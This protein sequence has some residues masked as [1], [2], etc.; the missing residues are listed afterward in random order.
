MK[1][2]E[3]TIDRIINQFGCPYPI[4]WTSIASIFTLI[5][6]I[7]LCHAVV[8]LYQYIQNKSNESVSKC[9]IRSGMIIIIASIILFSSWVL[10]TLEIT[11]CHDI[12]NYINFLMIVTVIYVLS[13][14]VQSYTLLILFYERL[15]FIFIGTSYQLSTCTA[16]FYKM[17]FI[18]TPIS[19]IMVGFS[20][21]GYGEVRGG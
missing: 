8:A 20:Y 16:T 15:H 19:M 5:F 7:C 4:W 13:S 1:F 21:F 14:I 18:I 9:S 10:I 6:F 2:A 3:T 12:D 11:I 17:T